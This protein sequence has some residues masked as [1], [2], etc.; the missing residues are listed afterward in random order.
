MKK[1]ACI[2][3]GKY[4]PGRGTNHCKGPSAG[5]RWTLQLGLG[6]GEG[7]RTLGRTGSSKGLSATMRSSNFI[8][9]RRGSQWVVGRMEVTL[10]NSLFPKITQVPLWSMDCRGTSSG[11]R[12]QQPPPG[13]RRGCS[14][15][16]PPLSA[17]PGPHWSFIPKY[18]LSTVTQSLS[19]TLKTNQISFFNITLAHA[20]NDKN[21]SFSNF[22]SLKLL[23]DL[24]IGEE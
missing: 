20:K 23:L 9:S 14:P 13:S 1:S 16:S 4:I 19:A 11:K 7:A 15:A 17:L 5:Q 2:H 8:L 10:M 6:M 24:S 18:I 22:S 12:R 21:E 3:P